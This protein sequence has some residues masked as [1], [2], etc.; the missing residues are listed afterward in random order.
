LDFPWL[1]GELDDKVF[2][3]PNNTIPIITHHLL[4]MEQEDPKQKIMNHH[5]NSGAGTKKQKREES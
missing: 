1:L 4:T 3:F 2:F 5:M